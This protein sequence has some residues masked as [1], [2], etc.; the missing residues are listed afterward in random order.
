[1]A[2]DDN[3]R[4]ENPWSQGSNARWN[5][6]SS[7]D[8]SVLAGATT[9]EWAAQGD[10]Q[11][12]FIAEPHRPG[13]GNAKKSLL[14]V[15]ITFALVLVILGAAITAVGWYVG[16]FD[17]QRDSGTTVGPATSTVYVTEE[18]TSQ[19]SPSVS[20]PISPGAE[21]AG[22]SSD[23]ANE[24]RIFN[25]ISPGNSVTSEPFA[26]NVGRAFLEE[27][28]LSGNTSPNI[29]VWSPVTEQ[30]YSMSCTDNGTYVVCRGGN[31]AVVFIE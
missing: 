22:S 19:N 7:D 1:M 11:G 2:W 18:P 21:R 14:W 12:P 15:I 9:H 8:P 6:S 5:E 17:N 10:N 29:S 4:K 13:P 28:E 3:G 16:W 20:P 26:T 25:D 30:T 23:D 24:S 31:N 27:Y